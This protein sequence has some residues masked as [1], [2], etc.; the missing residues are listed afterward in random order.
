MKKASR[1]WRS[2][3][4]FQENG[5][6]LIARP[7]DKRDMFLIAEVRRREKPYSSRPYKGSKHWFRGAV[8]LANTPSSNLVCRDLFLRLGA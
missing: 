4:W 3:S 7:K 6:S 2:W 8:S 1:A 5:W